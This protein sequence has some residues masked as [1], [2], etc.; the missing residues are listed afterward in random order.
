[1]KETNTLAAVSKHECKI[2]STEGSVGE[3]GREIDS[4][5]TEERLLSFSTKCVTELT[6]GFLCLHHGEV[7]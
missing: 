7:R 4:R 2:D 6:E 5:K 1:M 3:R